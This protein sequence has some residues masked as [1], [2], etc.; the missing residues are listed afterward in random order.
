MIVMP[1]VQRPRLVGAPTRDRDGA[2]VL[3]AGA[4]EFAL[5]IDGIDAE[6]V[7]AMLSDLDGTRDIEAIV[8]AHPGFGR[9]DV[10]ALVEDLDRNGLIDDAERPRC[11]SGKAVLLEVEDT[12]NRLLHERLYRNRFWRNVL[13]DEGAVPENVYYGMCIENYHFL[14]RESYFDAPALSY[15][16]STPARVEMNQ[17]YAEEFAHDELLLKALGAIGL[18]REDLA[19]TMPLPETMAM[20]NALSYWARYDPLFFFTTLGILEGKDVEVDSYVLACER[21]G[22]DPRFIAPIRAHAEINMK[23]EHGNLTRKIF[24]AIEAIDDETARR[25]IARTH[26]FIELY[27]NFY[28]AIW[29]HYSTTPTLLRR[30]SEV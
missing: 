21:R 8:A 3:K 28:T 18:K 26:L 17:F 11:R 23:G 22:L 12:A 15:P 27:D 7:L 30:L 19:E 6:A 20:C 14:F 29:T 24:A 1:A 13:N 5:D 25:L 4:G 2:L 10:T 16:A 9:R